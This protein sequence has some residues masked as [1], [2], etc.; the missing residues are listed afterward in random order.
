M[1]NTFKNLIYLF[2]QLLMLLITGLVT[3]L[4]IKEHPIMLQL[5]RNFNK[6]LQHFLTYHR[7]KWKCKILINLIK[8]SL[9]AQGR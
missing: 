1:Y 2:L 6:L 9:Q 3:L 4:Q 7:T 8:R 5:K